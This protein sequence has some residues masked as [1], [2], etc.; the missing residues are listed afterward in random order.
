MYYE[1][2]WNKRHEGDEEKPYV[3]S[4]CCHL[5]PWW[6]S[7]PCCLWVCLDHL[8]PFWCP[9]L[10]P[11]LASF[12]IRESWFHPCL[13]SMEELALVAWVWESWSHT[14][15]EQSKRADIG[16]TG[17]EERVRWPTQWPPRFRSRALSWSTPTSKNFWS[18]WRAKSC[19]TKYVG[20]P[21][22]RAIT[23]YLKGVPWGSSLYSTAEAKGLK[24]DQWLMAINICKYSCLGKGN[25][26]WHIAASPVMFSLGGVQ[27]KE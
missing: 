11:L 5:R 8:G 3:S 9:E 20:S 14:S 22:H 23:G 21:W 7:G 26:V 4:L 12:N 1:D 2:R 10:V 25:K 6:C 17:T 24:L 15:P 19:R 16:V 18:M 13:G 27:R